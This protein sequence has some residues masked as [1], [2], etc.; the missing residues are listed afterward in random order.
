MDD[1]SGYQPNREQP[2]FV[3]FD[4]SRRLMAHAS[5]FMP[6]GVSSNFRLGIHPT[7]LVIERADGPFLFDVDGNRLIDYYLGMGPNILGHNPLAVREAV[8]A[9]LERGLLYGAQS[10]LEAQVAELFC[11]MVPC[12]D[13]VRFTGSGSEA[14]QAALRLARAATGRNVVIKFEGHY[15]GWFDNVLVSNQATP[16]NAGPASRPNRNPGSAGQDPTAWGNVQVLGWNDPAAVE[17]RLAKGDV[18][19]VIMEPMMCNAGG[20]LPADGYLASVRDACTRSGTVLIFDEV[21]TGFRVS[22]GGAQR[23]F[24]VTPDLATFG[25]CIANGFPLAAVA[26]R[27]DLMDQLVSG[28]V[29]HGGTYNAHPA[30]MAAAL[31]TLRALQDGRVIDTIAPLGRRLMDGI[32]SRLHE[33]GIP[34]VV[35]G[36]PQIFYVGFGLTAPPRDYRDLMPTDRARYVRFCGEMLKRRVRTLERGAWFMSAAHDEAIIDE[37]LAVV[38]ETAR[39]V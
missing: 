30:S 13:K 19:A 12:A 28:G 17:T 33:A 18:A 8:A 9:Q 15:H 5:R 10:R 3:E 20:I 29:V 4:E 11:A 2:P 23:I 31:A 35:T 22:P 1:T 26:G 14:V 7:P 27:G 39:E 38:A 37:T 36:L 32:A 25:K 34:A 6:G 24:G 16:D 21:V